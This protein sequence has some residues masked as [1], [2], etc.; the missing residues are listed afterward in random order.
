MSKN[1][2][3]FNIKDL[4]NKNKIESIIYLKSNDIDY[5]IKEEFSKVIEK[6]KIIKTNKDIGDELTPHKSKVILY[7][8][9]GTEII[10]PNL[11]KMNYD[12]I[13]EWVLK[14]NLNV[15]LEDIYDEEKKKGTF[16]KANVKKGDKI[17][18]ND[19]IILYISKGTL[20]G[21]TK[22]NEFEAWAKRNNINYKLEY[23]YNEKITEGDIIRFSVKAG[24]KLNSKTNLTVYIAKSNNVTV[25]NFLNKNKTEIKE[26]CNNL[27]L[28]CYFEYSQSNKTEDICIKQSI[29]ANTSIKK[30]SQIKI[31]LS[32]KIDNSKSNTNE[33]KE[34]NDTNVVE[35][36]KNSI[37]DMFGL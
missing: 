24:S 14:N 16:I 6:N 36:N 22:L 11:S 29:E 12:E 28:N 32:K 37:I 4:T 31:T 2:K 19:E 10:V 3:K 34:K 23:E 35:R 20:P 17:S 1:L 5:E 13:I 8:S 18:E 26:L 21:F 25:P 27:N 30:Y 15:K 9:I 7:T 33:N